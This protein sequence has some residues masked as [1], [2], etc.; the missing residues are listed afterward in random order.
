MDRRSSL[1]TL[2]LEHQIGTLNAHPEAQP[3]IVSYTERLA[4]LKQV[5][6]RDFCEE[7]ISDEDKTVDVV[8]DIVN[9][10]NSGGTKLSKGD[11]H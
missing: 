9:R 4:R 10:V 3:R 7:K 2:G 8:V 1:S 6:E 11:L 5:L